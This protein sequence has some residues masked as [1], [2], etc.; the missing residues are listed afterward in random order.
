[1]DICYIDSSTVLKETGSGVNLISGL[2][3]HMR[4]VEK[5]IFKM[6]CNILYF[7]QYLSP[8]LTLP[9]LKKL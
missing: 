6:L 1:M 5:V 9:F 7:Q 8:S 4:E 2:Y 3:V